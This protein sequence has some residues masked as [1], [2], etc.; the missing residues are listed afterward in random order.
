MKAREVGQ[1]KTVE[2]EEFAAALAQ[3][4]KEISNVNDLVA[5]EEDEDAEG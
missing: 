4:F 5:P 3:P 2:N 1:G